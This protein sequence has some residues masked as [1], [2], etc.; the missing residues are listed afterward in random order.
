MDLFTKEQFKRLA[1]ILDNVG[2]IS[3]A[4]LI[5]PSVIGAR[6]DVGVALTGL[7][8]TLLVWWTSLRLERKTS[9]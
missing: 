6:I 5:I 1:N 7:L 3:L 8:I 9:T 4:G 2:Q